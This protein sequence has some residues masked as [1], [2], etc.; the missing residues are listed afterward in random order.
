MNS[1]EYILKRLAEVEAENALL[2]A[3][4]DRGCQKE[5]RR[6]NI[7]T[8]DSS[9]NKPPI[10]RLHKE[11]GC[12]NKPTKKVSHSPLLD[13]FEQHEKYHLIFDRIYQRL[14]IR[15]IVAI[16][17]T[18]RR[19]STF[20]KNMLPCRWNINRRLARFV[21]DP[22]EFR[23]KLGE[24][25]ALISGTFA[26]L[27][28]A[29]L[30]WLDSGLDVYVR[31]GSKAD[32]LTRY[33]GEDT[34]YKFDYSYDCLDDDQHR[35]LSKVSLPFGTG[36]L[37][38]TYHEKVLIFRR[39][40]PPGSPQIRFHLTQTSPL[41]SI[42][43]ECAFSTA[44]VNII[45]WNKAYCLFP[46]VTF[47]DRRM[48]LLHDPDEAM[49]RILSRY[50]AH[51]WRTS[52]CVDYDEAKE[53]NGLGIR[54]NLRRIGDPS[55]WIIPLN[56]YRVRPPQCLDFVLESC[57]FQIHSTF[58]TRRLPSAV[59]KLQTFEISAQTFSCCMLNYVYTFHAQDISWIV[60]LREKLTRIIMLELVK[61]GDITLIT[62]TI[63]ASFLSGEHQCCPLLRIR[64]AFIRPDNWECVDHMIAAWLDEWR[65]VRSDS[66]SLGPH[67]TSIGHLRTLPRT[68]HAVEP[69][70]PLILPSRTG[71]VTTNRLPSTPRPAPLLS[72]RSDVFPLSLR[73]YP[74]I[75]P[76]SVSFND[77]NPS[78]ATPTRLQSS[79]SS[80]YRIASAQPEHSESGSSLPGTPWTRP[81]MRSTLS[82]PQYQ[83]P[84]LARSA[85]AVELFKP[86]DS[87][88][89]ISLSRSIETQDV[90]SPS[91]IQR[92]PKASMPSPLNLSSPKSSPL[93]PDLLTPPPDLTPPIVFTGH[94]SKRSAWYFPS[95][96]PVSPFDETIHNIYR[97][98]SHPN[99]ASIRSE[100]MAPQGT[101]WI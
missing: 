91:V 57:T 81:A 70:P 84:Q 44:H 92:R 90:E 100:E 33:I 12:L 28:F 27:F 42:L 4:L 25:D 32:A 56:T 67:P 11:A 31:Q 59:T 45:T 61:T 89:S 40:D 65:L 30:Y 2:R 37:Y 5:P 8:L 58:E 82:N 64:P 34:G 14:G 21:N 10:A 79:V 24:A 98:P 7:S 18:C 43:T 72:S 52:D 35:T 55:T 16:S 80:I 48:Y 1:T 15:E 69:A 29:Q 3:R 94:R 76:R 60:F 93:A 71:Y 74:A 22:R 20:Y 53:C 87:P 23:S 96:L 83:K 47:V 68:S 26:L 54:E 9:D 97:K 62:T 101:N 63:R 78:G 88:R 46:N 99:S 50:S 49:R 36:M 85:T 66:I 51:G 39:V 13:F 95:N 41:H 38:T 6:Q 73:K 77:L 17:R 86:M 19:L 75:P